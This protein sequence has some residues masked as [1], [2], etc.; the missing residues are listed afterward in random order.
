MNGN[1]DGCGP[2]RSAAIP[3]SI[4][5]AVGRKGNWNTARRG[6]TSMRG[7]SATR[8]RSLPNRSS[9]PPDRSPSPHR[10]RAP[11]SNSQSHSQSHSHSHSA[12]SNSNSHHHRPRSP[13]TSRSTNERRGR[14]Y[15]RVPHGSSASAS[16]SERGM[17]DRD[18]DDERGVLDRERDREHDACRYRP[19][20]Y[21]L[22]PRGTD[23][24]VPD[25][26]SSRAFV[27][28]GRPSSTTLAA[29][30]SRAFVRPSS[31]R[32]R[33]VRPRRVSRVRSPSSRLVSQRV[34]RV[35]SSSSSRLVRRL[36]RSFPLVLVSSPL[37]H[38]F[39]RS[40]VRVSRARHSPVSSPR[41]EG[42]VRLVG[43]ERYEQLYGSGSAVAASTTKTKTLTPEVVFPTNEAGKAAAAVVDEI[44]KCQC[45][46]PAPPPLIV[47]SPHLHP[48]HHPLL[49]STLPIPPGRHLPPL[50]LIHPPPLPHPILISLILISHSSLLPPLRPTPFPSPHLILTVI[51]RT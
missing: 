13:S 20:A 4:P 40:C 30:S 26:S 28:H 2:A 49:P 51:L 8:S 7:R 6:M 29:R 47:V 50:F 1:G 11:S 14:S 36:A 35:R 19:Q 33:R 10:L 27:P 17:R 39:T 24:Y 3:I 5:I 37:A 48:T 46:S 25:S 9:S 22:P 21:A 34:P 15:D 44:V 18:R 32:P 12:P 43:A 16:A 45:P 42:V 38:A 41:R 31:F 23:T